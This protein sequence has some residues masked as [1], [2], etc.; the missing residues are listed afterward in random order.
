MFF[1][2]VLFL[3]IFILVGVAFFILLERK[4]LGYIQFRK[5]PSKLGFSGLF[6]PFS[7]AIS[8]FTKESFFIYFGN[9]FIY[10]IIPL[11]G[12][13][14]SCLIWLLYPTLYSYISMSLGLLIF[15]SLSGFGVYFIMLSG[16]SS[17]SLYSL[18]GCIRGV[19]QSISYEVSMF[20]V[21]LCKIMVIGVLNFCMFFF[22]QIYFWFI[23]LFFPLF[24]IFFSCILAE[25][26][27][28]PFD[29]AEGESELVSG[30]NVEYSSFS[31]SFI[32]LSE[33]MNIMFMS[34][35]CSL[36]FFGGDYYTFFF[37]LSV[38]LLCFS[39]IWVR[40][41]FPRYRYDK[42]MYLSWKCYLPVTL[43]YFFFC[44]FLKVLLYSIWF[45]KNK[46]KMKLMEF[47]FL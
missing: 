34:F 31:F 35:F 36:I 3:L 7:D 42:L 29:F 6:Q 38:L 24:L 25:T 26:N 27:R 4:I 37:F 8:L 43:N 44:M 15:I 18:I 39:F 46:M 13:V 20:M 5:G 11:L 2:D 16:W 23:F 28:S 40:G 33:Y 22:F 10:Y 14:F 12:M 30:F 47:W 17:N 1:F 9:F 19:A 41:T 21:V 32:V 45:Y